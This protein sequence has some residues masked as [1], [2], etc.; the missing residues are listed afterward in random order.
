MAVGD[1]IGILNT[2]TFDSTLALQPSLLQILDDL[3]CIGYQGP[4][5]DGW[6]KS[7]N[8]TPLGIISEP[9][10]NTL[11]YETVGS[12]FQRS[13]LMPPD[14]HVVSYSK[15]PATAHIDAIIVNA[16]G[17][18]SQHANHEA[19]FA[20][21]NCV[22]HQP[23]Y[24][25]DGI[26]AIAYD[27]NSGQA[28]IIT[29]AVSD[30]GQVAAALTQDF[31]VEVLSSGFSQI[32]HVADA[33]YVD[34]YQSTS[35]YGYARSVS[36][37]DVGV[38]AYTAYG[39][40]TIVDQLYSYPDIIKLKN[41]VFITA[42]KTDGNAGF[43]S[44]FQCADAG[45][46]TVPTNELY[47]FDAML[48]ETPRLVRITDEIFAVVYCYNGNIGRIKTIKCE[49]AAAA[50]WTLVSSAQYTAGYAQYPMITH[51]GGNVYGIVWGDA[52]PLGLMATVE[53]T[54]SP[55]VYGHNEM[56][57]GIGP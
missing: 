40:V 9:A 21:A 38:I 17:T 29:W 42:F 25:A 57:M 8:I 1:I 54:T 11:E 49:L 14:V 44:V 55:V 52:T 46:I 31:Q 36:I 37:S 48:A 39:K 20:A 30:Q 22:R 5:N 2:H 7:I 45:E 56:L 35:N 15:S 10:S 43:C 33:V 32:A 16:D 41:N 27:K 34:C 3:H 28:Y 47:A 23:I 13:C 53:I 19:Q 24:I 6:A 18:L 12:Q 50:T 4:D 26:V 51:R